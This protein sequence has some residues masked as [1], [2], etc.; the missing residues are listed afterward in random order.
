MGLTATADKRIHKSFLEAKETQKWTHNSALVFL[1]IQSLEHRMNIGIGM[2]NSKAQLFMQQMTLQGVPK[3]PAKHIV[4][5]KFTSSQGLYIRQ[6]HRRS[7]LW[8]TK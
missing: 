7:S 8:V 3:T 6:V 1:P 4:D 2:V 5:A